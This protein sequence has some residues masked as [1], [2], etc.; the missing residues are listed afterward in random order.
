MADP[1]LQACLHATAA[2]R[3]AGITSFQA[4]AT[5]TD[6]AHVILVRHGFDCCCGGRG[7]GGLVIAIRCRCLEFR[8]LRESFSYHNKPY[9]SI[10]TQDLE[11]L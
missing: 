6:H 7:G 8:V 5:I 11:T 10:L 3:T 4:A 9:P 2:D 1:L